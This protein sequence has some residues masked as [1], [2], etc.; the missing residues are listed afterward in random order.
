MSKLIFLYE[1]INEED[2]TKIRENPLHAVKI[3]NKIP[4]KQ[5]RTFLKD[6]FSVIM[7]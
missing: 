2:M 7:N 5:R 6:S 3:I 1:Q 4:K